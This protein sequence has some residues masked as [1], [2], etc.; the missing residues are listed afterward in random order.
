MVSPRLE[1]AMPVPELPVSDILYGYGEWREVPPVLR[2]TIKT[3][4]DTVQMQAA[5]IRQL[6][7]NMLTKAETSE[8]S[9]MD[10]QVSSKISYAEL[11]EFADD[12]SNRMLELNSSVARKAESAEVMSELA[13]LRSKVTEYASPAVQRWLEMQ[14]EK[15]KNQLL[16][17][18]SQITHHSGLVS[19]ALEVA[20]RHREVE[21]EAQKVWVDDQLRK[22]KK[23]GAEA[24]AR[25]TAERE[26]AVLSLWKEVKAVAE[27]LSLEQQ[28]RRFETKDGTDG[29]SARI[30]QLDA[31]F[32]QKLSMER[33]ARMA[34]DDKFAD[35]LEMTNREVRDVEKEVRAAGER[36]AKD[37]LEG[38]DGLRTAVAAQIEGEAETRR[39]AVLDTHEQL[40][41]V[42]NNIFDQLHI[43]DA[44][45]ENE[46]AEREKS[47]KECLEAVDTEKKA[48]EHAT[49]MG[50]ME[51]TSAERRLATQNASERT[52]R[53]ASVERLLE[54]LAAAEA[55]TMA[56]V[57]HE[58]KDRQAAM[59][60][61]EDQRAKS[62]DLL[63]AEE[64]AHCQEL[65]MAVQRLESNLASTETFLGEQGAREAED[66]QKAC[67]G[68]GNEIRNGLDTMRVEVMQRMREVEEN[69]IETAKEMT[70]SELRKREQQYDVLKKHVDFCTKGTADEVIQMWQYVQRID[71]DVRDV[72]LRLDNRMAK[73]YGRT[74][75]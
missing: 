11:N 24:T 57:S 59:Q 12:L 10:Q 28:E 67:H 4:Y 21:L 41:K 34:A 75:K 65:R 37:R 52:D 60:V 39:A 43:L 72:V 46:K 63:R 64:M 35:K 38:L 15:Q 40:S 29:L 68:L 44:A 36:E 62:D 32:V 27:S 1:S 50:G 6:Q 13:D 69:A 55:R 31:E 14:A 56:A 61:S 18:K 49:E 51:L 53:L 47:S 5:T 25:E 26:R 22:V 74:W 20:A 71:T 3:L 30:S 16:E 58:S 7:R 9:A 8:V 45:V 17:Q 70:D 48:R 42:E 73:I 23:G 66:R 33:D 54:S 19:E 2:S